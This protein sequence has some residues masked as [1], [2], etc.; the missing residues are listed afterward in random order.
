M[1]LAAGPRADI[2]IL[3]V[4]VLIQRR[5]GNGFL[6]GCYRVFGLLRI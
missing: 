5:K 4:P 1:F 6:C 2:R 3:Y